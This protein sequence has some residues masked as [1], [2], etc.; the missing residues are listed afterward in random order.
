LVECPQ[1][2]YSA[3]LY[4]GSG[5]VE[6]IGSKVQNA[7]VGDA[8]L[9]SFQ[10]CSN[11]KDCKENHPSYCQQFAAN[12]GGE[13]EIFEVAD[14]SKSSGSFFGQSSFSSLAIVKESS[15]VKVTHLIQDE[16]EL[17]LFAPMGCGFQTGVGTVDRLT[18]ARKQDTVVIMGLGGVGLAA[19]MVGYI[20]ARCE[21]LH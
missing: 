13:Q 6:E 8:V 12:Y 11:C 5:F 10:F 3:D 7:T 21:N 15:A 4:E 2:V 17:K 9:L 20:Y 1:L 16:E 18:A 19:I 14:G